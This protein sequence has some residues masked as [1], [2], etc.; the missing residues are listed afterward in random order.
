M[1]AKVMQ[2]FITNNS[3]ISFENFFWKM[4]TN[5][6]K[7]LAGIQSSLVAS[8]ETF[9]WLISTTRTGSFVCPSFSSFYI[10]DL[11]FHLT[12]ATGV[13][14]IKRV[15]QNFDLAS[16]SK[17]MSKEAPIGRGLVFTF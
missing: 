4:D 8:C 15:Q 10:S 17:R 16:T 2:L 3:L 14:S 11:L 13:F 12:T 7:I 1:C 9:L 5:G 6:I